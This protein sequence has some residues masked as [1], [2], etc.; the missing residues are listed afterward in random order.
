[1]SNQINHLYEFGEFRINVSQRLLERQGKEI[2]L[3][4]KVFDLLLV[5]VERRGQVVPKDQLMAE[6]W[7]DTFVEETNLKVNISILRKILGGS[8]EGKIIETLHKRGYRFTAEVT[9]RFAADS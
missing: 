6:I 4:P 9:E 5:L 2:S 7:P 3:Q 1:M 8:E